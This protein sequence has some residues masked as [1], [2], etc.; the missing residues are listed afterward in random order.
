[1]I[2]TEYFKQFLLTSCN[3]ALCAM[4]NSIKIRSKRARKQVNEAS[5]PLKI[6]LLCSE[7]NFIEFFIVHS[8]HAENCRAKMF[9]SNFRS[10]CLSEIKRHGACLA[11]K[12]NH[13][14]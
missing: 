7:Y 4:E 1:M 2:S 12:I 8:V 5:P 14:N 13:S 11:C 6:R 10:K 3:C 9:N